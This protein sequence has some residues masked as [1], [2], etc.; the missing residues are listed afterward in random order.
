TNCS[1]SSQSLDESELQSLNH[2]VN[3]KNYEDSNFLRLKNHFYPH[4]QHLMKSPI[5]SSLLSDKNSTIE[6]VLSKSG[7]M[8]ETDLIPQSIYMA[9]CM[10]QCS[11]TDTNSSLSSSLSGET[12]GSEINHDCMLLNN[13]NNH[14]SNL[15]LTR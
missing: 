2:V 3:E 5:K 12:S 1:D 14:P 10:K 4:L 11:R 13:T 8:Q 9:H 6:T 15:R 7:S